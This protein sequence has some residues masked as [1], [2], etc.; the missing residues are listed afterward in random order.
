MACA[1]SIVGWSGR[2]SGFNGEYRPTGAT[3]NGRPVF[4]ATRSAF[5]PWGAAHVYHAHGFWK[6]GHGDW[7]PSPSNPH[8]TALVQGRPIPAACFAGLKSEAMHPA[9]I[10]SN[11]A[12]YECTGG[13]N[14]CNAFPLPFSN[15]PSD[16]K[17]AEGDPGVADKGE[18]EFLSKLA[19]V[20]KQCDGQ[21][22]TS[23]MAGMAG[24]FVGG[25]VGKEIGMAIGSVAGP[26][27]MVVGG[28]IGSAVGASKGKKAAK[29]R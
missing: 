28:M 9:D 24:G 13:G 29:K 25:Q 21:K 27:G 18:D 6:I 3:Q 17:P 19:R 23:G 20:E 4:K 11:E 1:F 16:F 8:G 14:S 2:F 7:V 15:D 10:P 12:W 22:K 26:V 5:G